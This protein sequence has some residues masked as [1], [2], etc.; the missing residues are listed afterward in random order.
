MG[1]LFP[2]IFYKRTDLGASVFILLTFLHHEVCVLS[3]IK[4]QTLAPTGPMN[5]HKANSNIPTHFGLLSKFTPEGTGSFCCETTTEVEFSTTNVLRF[6][7][8]FFIDVVFLSSTVFIAV[9][10]I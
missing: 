5:A 9:W 10:C 6:Q 3:D 1:K 4:S 2:E 7:F 8:A